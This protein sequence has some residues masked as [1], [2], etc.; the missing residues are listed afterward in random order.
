MLTL[1]LAPRPSSP[2]RALFIGAHCD[3][4]EIGCGG[5]ILQ[6]VRRFPDLLVHWVVLSATDQR[7]QEVERSADLFLANV[8]A[9]ELSISRFRDGYLPYESSQV[10]DYFEAL[11]KRI[12]PDI[13]FTHYRQ[14][15]HQDHRFISELSWSTFR[16]QLILEYEIPKYESE[17]GA[18]NLFVPLDEEIAETKAR[19]L[20]KAYPSQ[21]DK[22][23]FTQD[24]FLAVMRLRGIQARSKRYAEAFYAPKIVASI[25]S[26]NVE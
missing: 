9:R 2:L 15:A 25:S 8:G 22:P 20:I 5:T 24:T 10:K 23:W 26:L 7:A 13:V 14:D 12:T 16:D 4:I 21:A 11:K 6:L 17:A 3:D 18:P 19:T 1:Q